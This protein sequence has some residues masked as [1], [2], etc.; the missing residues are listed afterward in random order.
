MMTHNLRN[1]DYPIR[2][3]IRRDMRHGTHIRIRIQSWSKYGSLASNELAY[4]LMRE[5]LSVT[6]SN[7]LLKTTTS[8]N[9]FYPL[10]EDEDYLNIGFSQPEEWIERGQFYLV[11]ENVNDLDIDFLAWAAYKA[12]IM[13]EGG[14]CHEVIIYAS[15]EKDTCSGIVGANQ[16]SFSSGCDSSTSDNCKDWPPP[17]AVVVVNGTIIPLNGGSTYESSG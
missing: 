17:P 6:R 4:P 14:C 5:L 16:F 13:V 11:P 7:Y 10:E 8:A 2:M 3:D 1:E 9:E 15:D 12:I